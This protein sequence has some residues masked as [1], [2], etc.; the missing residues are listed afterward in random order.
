[1]FLLIGL[2][3]KRETVE[4]FLSSKE[5]I[6]LPFLAAIGGM[7]LPALIFLGVNLCA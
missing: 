7:L 4:G 2:E 3:L 6:I 1:F 5:Q